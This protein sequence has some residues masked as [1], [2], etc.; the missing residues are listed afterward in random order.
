MKLYSVSYREWDMFFSNLIDCTKLSVG[1]N[2]DE[3]IE[4]VKQ[5]VAKDARDFKAC[6]IKAVFGHKITV[7]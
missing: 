4:R 7:E 2:K 3:A 5:V 1:E 6:K